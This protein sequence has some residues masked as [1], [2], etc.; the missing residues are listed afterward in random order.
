MTYSTEYGTEARH[1]SEMFLGEVLY[2]FA[3]M[4]YFRP[5]LSHE[6]YPVLV[7]GSADFAIML[8]KGR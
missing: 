6:G 5:K 3:A 2:T 7:S 4:F 8:T 1:V